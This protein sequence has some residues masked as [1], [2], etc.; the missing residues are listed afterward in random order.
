MNQ[1]QKKYFGNALKSFTWCSLI[2]FFFMQN[3]LTPLWVFFAGLSLSLAIIIDYPDYLT[4]FKN[5]YEPITSPDFLKLRWV[6]GPSLGIIIVMSFL[7]SRITSFGLSIL[8][9]L[10]SGVGFLLLVDL[11]SNAQ[12]EI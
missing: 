8:L 11:L 2:V 7:Y 12:D 9:G 5:Y 3:Q 10:L 4:K 6:M 1:F